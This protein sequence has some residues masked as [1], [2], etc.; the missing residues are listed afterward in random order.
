M[1]S[2]C[3]RR[4]MTTQC[5]EPTPAVMRFRLKKR[6]WR[7]N[8]CQSGRKGSR[9]REDWT[10]AA[11]PLGD[12]NRE[13]WNPTVRA[14]NRPLAFRSLKRFVV[15]PAR[16]WPS[17]SR[18]WSVEGRAVRPRRLL[19]ECASRALEDAA[20][21][22]LSRRPPACRCAC[23]VAD[24]DAGRAIV[25][26]GAGR[27]DHRPLDDVA[28]LADVAR[29]GVPLQRQS[30]SPWEIASIRLPNVF[31]N[32]STKRQTSSGMSSA[33]SRSGGT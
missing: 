21:V 8:F 2:A 20:D 22:R 16:A 33:R 26:R 23:C 4:R 25:S 24:D 30:C 5:I 12:K 28:Q 31:E 15:E 1:A 6:D 32:S 18:A 27:D 17:A 19:R 29:P 7:G 11:G 10:P 14:K 3:V 9:C 13:K